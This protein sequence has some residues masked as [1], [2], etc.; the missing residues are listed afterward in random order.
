[1]SNKFIDT[2]PDNDL[3]TM[4]FLSID[5]NKC[6]TEETENVM[7]YEDRHNNVSRLL[8]QFEKSLEEKS[9]QPVRIGMKERILTLQSHAV[10]HNSNSNTLENRFFRRND[11]LSET[12]EDIL[13]FQEIFEMFGYSTPEE[14]KKK[15]EALVTSKEISKSNQFFVYAENKLMMDICNKLSE[16]DVYQLYK[17]LYTSKYIED[18]N[19]DHVKNIFGRVLSL[20]DEQIEKVKGLKEVVF[21]HLVLTLMRN[22]LLNRLYTHVLKIALRKLIE[23]NKNG[24]L[25]FSYVHPMLKS[26]DQYPI[27]STPAGLCIIFSVNKGR[28]GAEKDIKKVIELFEKSFKYDVIVQRDPTSHDIKSATTEL[29]A[30]RNKFYDSLVVFFM[31]H[32]SEDHLSVSNGSIHRRRDLIDP[33]TEIEW[34]YKKPKLFFIQAC[35]VRMKTRKGSTACAAGLG[36]GVDV[37]S[38]SMGVAS[39]VEIPWKLAASNVWE[40]KYGAHTDFS[41]VN[42]SADTLV[43]YATMW[44]QEASRTSEGT[45]YIDTLVDQLGEFGCDESIE[46]VLHRVHI[47]VNSVALE[48]EGDSWK[49]APYFESSLQ[50]AFIFPRK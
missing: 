35:S 39:A 20:N 27:R 16:K 1:D 12:E 23:F 15:Y 26:L 8:H 45:L 28:E 37:D 41:C 29:T 18:L 38:R 40:S 50:K 49:Q 6:G 43:S 47:N 21:F 24:G 33:F 5:P 13:E 11:Q 42:K 48:T 3:P 2:I 17:I 46:N 32:G 44:Y 7:D 30:A 4:L 14:V 9:L 10:N 34:F 22:N 36:L 25:E 19:D 31:G